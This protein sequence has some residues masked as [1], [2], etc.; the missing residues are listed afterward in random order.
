VEIEK[1]LVV[2]EALVESASGLIEV[3]SSL[4]GEPAV[5]YVREDVLGE[6]VDELLAVHDSVLIVT[7]SMS[8]GSGSERLSVGCVD[9]CDVCDDLLAFWDTFELWEDVTDNGLGDAFREIVCHRS[10]A[11]RN[12]R[13]HVADDRRTDRPVINSLVCLL[14]HLSDRVAFLVARVKP[15]PRVDVR[16]H[17]DRQLAACG[18]VVMGREFGS[19]NA[20]EREAPHE[21]VAHFVQRG[22]VV[23]VHGGEDPP[24]V[25]DDVLM[26]GG[27]AVKMVGSEKFY[28]AVI[29]RE[30]ELDG[31][32]GEQRE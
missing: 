19:R 14:P 15:F 12:V 1:E 32:P 10:T 28:F 23:R 31:L 25:G 27:E 16:I 2:F 18:V 7:W 5:H 4:L 22:F 8:L 11:V 24:R 29:S 30:G 3:A 6:T 21:R 20:D 13:E 17:F 9:G 26:F